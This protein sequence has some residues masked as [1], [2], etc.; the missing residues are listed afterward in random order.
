MKK[1]DFPNPSASPFQRQTRWSKRFITTYWTVIAVH[2]VAQLL[3]F[4]LLPYPADAHTFYYSIL[5]Y[6]TLFMA[7]I[8]ALAHYIQYVSGKYAYYSLLVAGTVISMVLIHLNADIRIMSAIMLLPIFASTFFFRLRLTF[9][10]ASLQ[11]VG[12]AALYVWDDWFRSFISPFDL[13]A[14][15]IFIAVSTWVACIIIISGREVWRNLEHTLI[16]KQDLI[17]ENAIISQLSKTDALTKLFNHIAFHEFYEKALEFGD[18]GTP[19]HLC[20]ID[21]DNFKT[22]ND[23]YGHRVGDI[24]LSRVSETIQERI[25]PVDIA[26]RYG[27]EEFALLLFE[28]TFDEAYAV[29]ESIRLRLSQT[30]HEE[31]RDTPVTLSI[32]L[33][34]YAITD[35][36]QSLFEDVDALLYA[37]KRSGKNRT[38]TPFHPAPDAESLAKRGANKPSSDIVQG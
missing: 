29:I 2:A 17:V 36:K 3:S 30:M 8:V 35:T 28:Q 32:G 1:S 12:F 38:V 5:L 31:L 27:G 15:P 24:I 21:I 11:I 9:F 6:P 20:L 7:G 16:A 10:S 22:I 14:I 37:A 25:S 33:K 18:E 19:F 4:L 23:T 26:C 34:S 13:I